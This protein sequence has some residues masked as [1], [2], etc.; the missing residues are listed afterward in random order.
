MILNSNLEDTVDKN[1]LIKR[2]KKEQSDLN[3]IKFYY[4]ENQ[5]LYLN[6]IDV[7]TNNI[8]FKF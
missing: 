3:L 4:Y 7:K 6:L 1:Y 2:L 8:K 5:K